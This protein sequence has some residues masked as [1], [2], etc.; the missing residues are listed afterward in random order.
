[1]GIDTLL[2]VL[3]SDEVVT[4]SNNAYRLWLG[5]LGFADF[6]HNDGTLQQLK[7]NGGF[8]VIHNQAVVD[9]IMKYDQ[10]VRVFYE[11]S[12]LMGS[13]LADQVMF[14]RMFDFIKIKRDGI[15]KGPIPLPQ[16]SRQLLNQAYAN[17]KTWNYGMGSLIYCLRN[18]NEE[19]KRVIKFIKQQYDVEED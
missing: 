19:G 3:A 5:N 10:V 8:R 9:S 11:Q 12:R 15:N 17:R 2:T 13:A 16:E 7:N 14:G 6:V 18:V 4:N 1:M